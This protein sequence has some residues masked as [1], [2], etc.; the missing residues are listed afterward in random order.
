MGEASRRHGRLY[1]PD[2]SDV[3][4]GALDDLAVTELRDASPGGYAMV[5][6]PVEV[7]S[8]ADS[9]GLRGVLLPDRVEP[10]SLVVEPAG[11]GAALNVVAWGTALSDGDVAVDWERGLLLFH[12]GQGGASLVASY[13]GLG[14]VV[15]A[16]R[17]N[18]MQAQVLAL[19]AAAAAV[20]SGYEAV[21]SGSRNVLAE[22]AGTVFSNGGAGTSVTFS[23]PSP[24]AG[25]ALVYEF[26]RVSNHDVY[27]NAPVGGG[28]S[29]PAAS[30][31][32]LTLTAQDAAVRLAV[33][34]DGI[35][36]VLSAV[37]SWSLDTV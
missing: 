25:R 14:G 15:T 21:T 28:F 7:P 19:G 3:A 10:G 37:G 13:T 22:E 27:V 35:A 12:A 34:P 4:V 1:Q 5:E 31:N 29:A 20:G 33:T 36:R 32:L 8:A 6:V 23:L 9:A 24:V 30:G 16:T 2:W 26:A 17:W 18:E 11:G